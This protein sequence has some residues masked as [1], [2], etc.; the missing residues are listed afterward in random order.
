MLDRGL[1]FALIA[2]YEATPVA[3]AIFLTWNGTTVYK[4]SASDSAHWRLNPN[5]LLLSEAIRT[6]CLAG[7]RRFDFG[8][9][10][11][12][13][14]G[15]R[16]FKRSW[17]AEEF[18]LTYSTFG[19]SPGDGAGEEGKALAPILRRTPVWVTRAVGELLYR[20]AA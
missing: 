2:E 11:V 16:R 10:D 4:Y 5:N 14:E 19:A 15:L 12:E 3:G 6:S 20:Y 18:P 17:G 1:G 7:S 13:A 9:S 8:R